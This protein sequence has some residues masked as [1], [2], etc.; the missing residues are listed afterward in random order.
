[1]CMSVKNLIKSITPEFLLKFYY[2][3]KNK[4]K[5]YY[6]H[7]ELDKKLKKYLNY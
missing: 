2:D 3:Y 4:R 1:M 6:G 7:H 5:I